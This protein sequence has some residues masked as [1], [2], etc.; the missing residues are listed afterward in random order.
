MLCPA[1][2]VC[3]GTQ[4]GGD[5]LPQSYWLFSARL[6]PAGLP[7]KCACYKSDGGG[8]RNLP[9]ALCAIVERLKILNASLVNLAGD[10]MTTLRLI[11]LQIVQ[12]NSSV[13]LLALA[14]LITA[15]AF[16]CSE[17]GRT[18]DLILHRNLWRRLGITD[19]T[20]V[21]EEICVGCGKDVRSHVTNG[22][23]S[24]LVDVDSGVVIYSNLREESS[25]HSG[26]SEHTP[27][28]TTIDQ[29]FALIQEAKPWAGDGFYVSYNA[30]IGYPEMIPWAGDGFY[31]SYNAEIGYPEMIVEYST[32]PNVMDGFYGVRILSFARS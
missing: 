16:V 23:V 9:D 19:Y 17:S 31:V 10:G 30:E 18:S 20:F 3:E 5:S 8:I 2:S 6:V 7:R 32:D 14:V 28:I 4:I 25:V 21:Y 24:T 13:L 15:S 1:P 27:G 26:V 11:K 29:L 12:I 22:V